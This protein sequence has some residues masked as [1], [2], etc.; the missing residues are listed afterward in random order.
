VR[1]HV[2]AKRYLC[3]TD[4]AYF[5]TLSAASVVTLGLQGGPMSRTE[6][7][8][9]EAEPHFRDAIRLRQWDDQAKIV[10]LK[11][12]DFVSYGPLIERLAASRAGG[13]GESL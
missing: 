12:P 1:L 11:T 8:A 5:A 9:F 4:P 3:A 7:D 13:A 6:A 2:P 10:G